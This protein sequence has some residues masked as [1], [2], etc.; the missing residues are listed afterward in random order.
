MLL[1]S[2][3][4]KNI[5]YQKNNIFYALRTPSKVDIF[6]IKDRTLKYLQKY[7]KIFYLFVLFFNAAPDVSVCVS[8]LRMYKVVAVV[9]PEVCSV[10]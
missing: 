10:Y 4:Q 2:S 3:E 6:V 9:R 5:I 7:F 1:C 8:V